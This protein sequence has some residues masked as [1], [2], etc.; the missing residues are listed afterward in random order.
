MLDVLVAR[1]P[2]GQHANLSG[3]S[4]AQLN[5]LVVYL[6]QIDQHEP[7]APSRPVALLSPAETLIN[8]TVAI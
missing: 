3:L 7:E 5:D 1:N 2:S 8:G 4:S 6:L